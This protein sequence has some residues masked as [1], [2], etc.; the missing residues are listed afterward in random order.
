MINTSYLRTESTGVLTSLGSLFA[1]C[2]AG[3]A[4]IGPLLGIT[5]G[6]SGLGWLTQYSYLTVPASI[7]SMVLLA[8]A[9]YVFKNRKS[10]CASRRRHFLNYYFLV[11]TTF[12]VVGI[13]AFEYLVLPN[14]L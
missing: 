7:V 1:S 11:I 2:I 5:L 14:M 4:C 10:S 6:L 12:I 13:N 8:L 9:I 3:L